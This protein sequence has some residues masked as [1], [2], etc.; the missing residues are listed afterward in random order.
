MS[1]SVE[2]AAGLLKSGV[3]WSMAEYSALDRDS[4]RALRSAQ[5]RI[6]QE[7]AESVADVLIARVEAMLEGVAAESADAAAKGLLEAFK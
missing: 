3:R 1:L 6:D 7:R 5:E 4:R 2:Q